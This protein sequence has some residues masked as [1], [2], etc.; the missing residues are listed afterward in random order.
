MTRL[1]SCV[2]LLAL[3]LTPLGCN[4]TGGVDHVHLGRGCL[5]REYGAA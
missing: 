1:V 3:F 2:L 5:R 4:P